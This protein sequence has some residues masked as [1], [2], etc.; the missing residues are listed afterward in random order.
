[1]G[2]RRDGNHYTLQKKKKKEDL[3]R[4]EENCYSIS[5]SNKTMINVTKEHSDIHKKNPSRRISWR[6]SL[7]N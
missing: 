5:D 7:R 3:V 1:M 2:R 6:K 4:N